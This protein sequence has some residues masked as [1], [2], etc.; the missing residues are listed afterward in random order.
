MAALPEPF[1]VLAE[2]VAAVKPVVELLGIR[3][4]A[5][6]GEVAGRWPK[7]RPDGYPSPRARFIKW[8]MGPGAEDGAGVA[9]LTGA[10]RVIGVPTAAAAAANC[11]VASRFISRR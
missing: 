8:G 5:V 2:L 10:D 3:G 1:K 11:C 4:L 6:H 7:T 9:G